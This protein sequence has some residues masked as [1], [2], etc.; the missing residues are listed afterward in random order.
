MIVI[1]VQQHR[2]CC[3]IGLFTRLAIAR[4]P[5]LRICGSSAAKRLHFRNWAT[6]LRSWWTITDSHGNKTRYGAPT[7]DA[8]TR[9][10][11]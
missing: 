8:T 1:N 3:V 11:I 9:C 7:A 2:I 5:L 10:C 6:F 4:R